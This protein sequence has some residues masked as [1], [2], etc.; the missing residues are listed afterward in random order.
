M[1][2]GRAPFDAELRPSLHHQH[3]LVVIDEPVSIAAEAQEV[4]CEFADDPGTLSWS[5]L[6]ERLAPFLL[7]HKGFLDLIVG[8][9]TG[10]D[11]D[12]TQGPPALS[13]SLRQNS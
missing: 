8:Y 1:I 10:F 2:A 7:K 9:D 6:T 12:L 4:D 5:S 13:G 3:T 11:E